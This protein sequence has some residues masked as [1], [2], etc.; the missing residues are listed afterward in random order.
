MKYLNGLIRKGKLLRTTFPQIK[1]QINVICNIQT[2][3]PVATAVLKNSG[4]TTPIK[5]SGKV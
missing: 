1:K 3:T 5:L 4:I 2:Y